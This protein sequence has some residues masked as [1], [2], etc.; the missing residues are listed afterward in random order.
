MGVGVS[1]YLKRLAF[2]IMAMAIGVSAYGEEPARYTP[3]RVVYDFT[4][5]DLKAL[6]VLLDRVGVLQDIYNSDPFEASI[7]V[8]LHDAAIPLFLSRNPA[9]AHMLR[10]AAGLTMTN[11]I[12]FRVCQMSARMQGFSKKDFPEFI[13][14]VPMA[15]AELV[16]LQRTGY[17]YLH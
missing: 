13:A 14:F 17:A 15:D 8:V 10:R 16:Q 12:Q 5:A 11:V 2:L 4:R 1:R 7:I 9:N 3:S 6:Q